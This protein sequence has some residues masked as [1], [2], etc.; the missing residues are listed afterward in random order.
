MCNVADVES[1]AMVWSAEA[2]LSTKLKFPISVIAVLCRCQIRPT[3]IGRFSECFFE[4][5][6]SY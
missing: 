3:R 2:V 5:V 6:Y 1:T 4:V